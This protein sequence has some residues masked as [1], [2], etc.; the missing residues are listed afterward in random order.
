MSLTVIA[1]WPLVGFLVGSVTGDPTGWHEDRAVVRL[2]GR[3]TWLLVLPC[4][5]RVAVQGPMYLA[6]RKGWWD[7]DSAIAALGTAKLAMGWPLQVAGFAAMA[8]LLAR[9]R[10]PVSAEEAA[11]IEHDL[12]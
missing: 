1:R 10:T 6:G 8:W 9:N 11:R 3:L 2:C 4:L 5:L 12:G 7:P